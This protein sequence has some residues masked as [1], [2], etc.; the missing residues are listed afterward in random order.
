MEELRR[1]LTQAGRQNWS[2]EQLEQELSQVGSCFAFSV[3]IP[4]VSFVLN[5]NFLY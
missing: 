1:I 4:T 2:F 3:W 5:L